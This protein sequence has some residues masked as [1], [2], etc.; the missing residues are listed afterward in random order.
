MIHFQIDNEGIAT[1]TWDVPGRTQ[2]VLNEASTEAFCNAL[3]RALGNPA[4]KGVLI[5]SAKSDF[6]VGGDLDVLLRADNAEALFDGITRW[7]RKLRVMETGGKPV[8]AALPGSAL[9][10]GLEL[11]LACHYRVAADN[12]IARF[13]LTEVTIG[14][15]PG[16]GGTQRLPRLIG[17]QNA[18]LLMLEGTR[19]S[20]SEAYQTGILHAVVPAGREMETARQWLLGE[21]Q[22]KSGQPWDAKGYKIPGCA[23]QGPAGMQIFMTGNAMLRE[24]TNGNYPAARNIMACVYEG[25][26]SDIDTGLKIEAR[27][28]TETVLTPEAKNMIRLLFFGMRDANKLANRPQGVPTGQFTKVGVLGA[29]LMGAG[30]A[31]ATAGA[32]IDVV[33]LDITQEAAERGKDYSRQLLAK[34]IEKGR[35]TR[36]GSDDLLVRIHPT[37]DFA[38]LTGCELVIEAV[39]ENRAIKAEVARKSEAAVAADCIYASSTST[40]PITGLAEARARPANFIGLH[41]FSLAD[42]MA[43]VEI[44]VGKDTSRETLAR[45]MDYVR[46]IGKTPIVI[47]DSRGFYTSR[48]F[49]AYINEGLAM[50]AEG[51]SPALIDNAGQLAGMPVGPLALTDEVSVDLIHKINKQTRAEI[52]GT[53]IQP[54]V[55]RVA[56]KM[57]EEFQRLG[58]KIGKGFYDYP[59]GGKRGLWPGLAEHFPPADEQPPVEEVIERLIMIQSV[60]ATRCLA[61]N[62][63]MR[64]MDA[65]VGALLGWGYPAF[66]GGPVGWIQTMGV[67]RFVAAAERL[68]AKHGVRFA[69]PKLLLEMVERGETFYPR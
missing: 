56:I 36:D 43:L 33:L 65:D 30:I 25:L 3:D 68:A 37:A 67:A 28:F 46:A 18:L 66:R 22:K 26:Q 8:A 34:R 45:S 48:V 50:L 32:G 5:T 44:T 29:G 23:V 20:A 38:D 24:R 7:N 12:P 10:G 31:Y 55:E 6:I 49:L 21:G 54:D 52:G 41:F 9:G 11:A 14:L 40:L 58:K 64:P 59:E 62:V 61:E 63:V 4:V 2:N 15:L 13:G 35:V 17:I 57:V 19:L 53:S 47:N 16:A 1:L 39:F 69:S 42:R 51:V 60:E 27:Y